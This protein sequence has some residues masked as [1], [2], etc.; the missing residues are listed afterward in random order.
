MWNGGRS[1]VALPLRQ[2]DAAVSVDPSRVPLHFTTHAPEGKA[3]ADV[4]LLHGLGSC[5]DDWGM[6]IPD[7]ARQYRVIAPDLPGHGQTGQFGIASSVEAM[8]RSVAGLLERLGTPSAH[9]VGLSLGG[10]VA[11]QWAID[12]PDQVRSLIA[13]NTFARLS[14]ARRGLLRMVGRILLLLTGRMERLGGWVAGGLFPGADQRDLRELAAAR[15]AG[16]SWR[17]YLQAALAVARFDCRQGLADI[18]APTL[19][20]AG[21]RDST[22]PM[23]PKLE[24][25]RRI[26]GARLE[27]ILGSGHVTPIDAAARFNALVMDFLDEV[28]RNAKVEDSDR[29]Y[30]G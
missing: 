21:E 16:N 15:I 2:R 30:V 18:R 22:V 3:R 24:L 8:A 27:V 14:L 28:E 7:L 17:G 25:A 19:V 26:P 11:L 5:G 4:V 12:R 9:A 20:V 29:R 1:R 13:V 6:Q 10:A 23:R